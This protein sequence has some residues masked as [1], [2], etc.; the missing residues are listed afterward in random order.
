MDSIDITDTD[1]SLEINDMNI[2]QV[3]SNTDIIGGS[4]SG[5]GFD[6]GSINQDYIY[7]GIIILLGL[8]GLF[9]FNY[10]QS[11]KNNQKELDCPGGFCTINQNETNV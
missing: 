4:G 9:V 1:F 2:N 5:S 3:N 6:W 7:I 10:Y 11:K 8:I